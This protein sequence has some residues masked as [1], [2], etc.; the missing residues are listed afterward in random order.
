MAYQQTSTVYAQIKEKI[1]NGEFKPAQN[2]TE[3]GLAQQFDASRVTIKK[4]LLIDR[5]SV[6]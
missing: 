6:V 4:A 2:L 5:K 3:Q 1:L